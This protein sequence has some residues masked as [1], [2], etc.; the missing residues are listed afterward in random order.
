MSDLAIDKQGWHLES[1][2]NPVGKGGLVWQVLSQ[3]AKE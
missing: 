2:Q 3:N 1:Y